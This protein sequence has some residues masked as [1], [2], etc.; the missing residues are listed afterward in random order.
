MIM[1]LSLMFV[2]FVFFDGFYF[3]EDMFEG[4]MLCDLVK[5][6]GVEVVDV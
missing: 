4:V 1:V 2:M 5:L 3:F 6:F